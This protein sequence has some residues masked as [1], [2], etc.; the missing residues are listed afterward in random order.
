M[1]YLSQAQ[2]LRVA[3]GGGPVEELVRIRIVLCRFDH[4][5]GSYIT[6]NPRG[7]IRTLFKP[8]TGSRYLLWQAQR[9]DRRR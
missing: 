3:P 9:Y 6:I 7:T 1:D 4:R 5:T 8:S 2:S